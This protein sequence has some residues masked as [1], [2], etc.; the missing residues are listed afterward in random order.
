MMI[1]IE[2]LDF[3]D[4]KANVVGDDNIEKAVKLVCR[5]FNGGMGLQSKGG[6]GWRT[7]TLG[8]GGSAISGQQGRRLLVGMEASRGEYEE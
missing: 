8:I 2:G 6:D 1:A 4:R 7:H 5:R 3:T